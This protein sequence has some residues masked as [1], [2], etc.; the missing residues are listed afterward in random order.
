M[1]FSFILP[2]S[3]HEVAVANSVP[4]FSHPQLSPTAT[5]VE[6]SIIIIFLP[7]H[8]P[9]SCALALEAVNLVQFCDTFVYD[10]SLVSVQYLN[11]N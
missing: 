8:S 6:I 5:S 11:C 3:N 2:Q 4:N 7:C 9:T 1:P 10:M